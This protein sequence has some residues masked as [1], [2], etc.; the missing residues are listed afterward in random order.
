VTVRRSGLLAVAAQDICR[1]V[2]RVGFQPELAREA[3]GLETCLRPPVRFLAGVMQFAMVC[4]AQWDRELIADLL[5]EP[6]WLRKTQVV[7][8]AGLSTADEAGLF[9]DEPQMLLVPQPFGFGEGQHALVNTGAH[10]LVR[11]RL[12]PF[13]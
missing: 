10:I 9:R 13:G 3:D 4:P 7:R 6:A 12:V 2:E 5:C 1:S 8:V 11:C